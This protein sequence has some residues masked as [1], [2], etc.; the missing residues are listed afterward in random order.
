MSGDAEGRDEGDVSSRHAP[1]YEAVEERSGARP[2]RGDVA[3]P[4]VEERSKRLRHVERALWRAQRARDHEAV[5]RARL[6]HHA[7]LAT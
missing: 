2:S 5:L 3:G 7:G 1:F 4:R 6:E